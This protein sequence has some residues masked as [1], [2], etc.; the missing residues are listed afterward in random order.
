M[1]GY[2]YLGII[3]GLPVTRE[4]N[5]ICP[6]AHSARTKKYCSGLILVLRFSFS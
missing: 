2:S 4:E 1:V 3:S 5:Q 6:L